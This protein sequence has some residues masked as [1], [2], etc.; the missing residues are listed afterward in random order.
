MRYFILLGLIFL[1]ACS[2][3]PATTDNV[4][5][6]TYN[7]SLAQEV[8]ADEYGMRK[9][10]MAFLKRGPNR[11]RSKEEADALQMAHMENIGRLAEEGLLSLA[12]PFLGGGD[13]RG[14]Y[15][16]NVDSIEEAERLTNTDPA[17]KAGSLT[18]ELIEW[19]GSAALMKVNDL[20]QQVA[21]VNF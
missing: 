4:E 2:T 5:P 1:M 11:D 6:L 14:I 16:F 12:G 15:V 3:K 8:G 18:M 9:Y 20:H 10:V 21:K 7:A 19:Y 17:I 13:L